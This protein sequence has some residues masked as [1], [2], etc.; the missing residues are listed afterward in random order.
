MRPK[1]KIH[2][3]ISITFWRSIFSQ[4]LSPQTLSTIIVTSSSL[5]LVS[6]LESPTRIKKYVWLYKWT[7]SEDIGIIQISTLCAYLILI[8]LGGAYWRCVLKIS[9]L[10]I[11]ALVL[12]THELP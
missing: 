8:L 11:P 10:I 6:Q 3:G 5:L 9:E 7:D 1:M 2:I 12:N 4:V